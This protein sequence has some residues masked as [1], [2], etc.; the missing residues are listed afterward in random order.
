MRRIGN[1][2]NGPLILVAH[3]L[4]RVLV[5]G[6]LLFSLVNHKVVGGEREGKYNA[7]GKGLPYPCYFDNVVALS[8]T[9]GHKFRSKLES[10][11]TISHCDHQR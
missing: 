4:K 6:V 8:M 11:L 7:E 3:S 10:T 2:R 9:V 1:Q 5:H